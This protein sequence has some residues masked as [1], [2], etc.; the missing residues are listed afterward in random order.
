MRPRIYHLNDPDVPP[1]AVYVGR[2]SPW[3][4]PFPIKKGVRTRKQALAQFRV[5]LGRNPT[6][7]RR[8]CRELVGRDL[9]CHCK[10]KDCHGDIWLELVNPRPS[11]FSSLIKESK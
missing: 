3:G 6:L 1:D 9:V 4:N 2:S 11:L 7:V 8:A 10:P 5:Y